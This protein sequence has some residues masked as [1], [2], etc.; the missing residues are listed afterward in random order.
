MDFEPELLFR[1]PAIAADLGRTAAWCRHI[2]RNTPIYS[3]VAVAFLVDGKAI[4]LE[5]RL[6]ERDVEFCEAPII[7]TASI[8][9]S[10]IGYATSLAGFSKCSPGT[11]VFEARL[12]AHE[13]L[14]AIM[15]F[16][17]GGLAGGK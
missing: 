5:P 4:V 2:H 11:V 15:E 10:S 16:Q 1:K 7:R 14:S 8:A 13:R 6:A 9:L 17:K 3:L 12:S